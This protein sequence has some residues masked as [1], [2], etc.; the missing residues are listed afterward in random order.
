DN[1][2]NLFVADTDNHI[3]R[4]V[5][6]VGTDWVVTTIAGLGHVEGPSDGLGYAARFR[7]PSGITVDSSGIVYVADYNNSSI[8]KLTRSG[9]SLYQ[10]TTIAGTF[11]NPGRLD[12]TGTNALFFWPTGIAVDGEGSIF[13]AEYYNNTIRKITSAGVVTT[14]AGP[15]GSQGVADGTGSTA[16][17]NQTGPAAVDKAGNLYVGDI[18]NDTIRKI[19]PAGVVSTLAGLAGSFVDSSSMSAD[20]AGNNARF[21]LPYGVAVDGG[22]NIFVADYYF[23]TIRR[24]TPAGL[25]TTIAGVPWS[26]GTND[27]VNENAR[28]RYPK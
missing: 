1:S 2:G 27:G 21:S 6:P 12:G 14:L 15:L 18:N 4:K 20:G 8:R 10:V 3:I 5:S 7:W 9:G 13:V 17:F 26:F 25:V 22:G 28:F 24:I 16:R 19:T 23:S 11:T